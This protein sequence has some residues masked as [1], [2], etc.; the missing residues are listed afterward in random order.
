M[1]DMNMITLNEQGGVVLITSLLILV[2]MTLLAIS[3]MS[4][5]NFELIMATNVQSQTKALA[6]AEI[7][8][9]EGEAE[10]N[11]KYIPGPITLYI[12]PSA[13]TSPAAGL[14]EYNSET[15]QTPGFVDSTTFDWDG[16]GTNGF[17]TG[18]TGNKYVI[19]YLGGWT[20]SGASLAG[21]V[22]I[23]TNGRYVYRL[24]GQ[25]TSSRGGERLVQTLFVTQ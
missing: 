25:G 23:G 11:T 20:M 9:S 21:G 14:Y 2:V 7:A 24:S 15:K 22:N 19:E 16:D 10:I 8:V 5:S 18:P 4:T 6:N 13:S 17:I 12:N 1:K 3:T